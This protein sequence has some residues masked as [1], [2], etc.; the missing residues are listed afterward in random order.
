[1]KDAGMDPLDMD[2]SQEPQYQ[3]G[4]HQVTDT[5]V[6]FRQVLEDVKSSPEGQET[7]VHI[8]RDWDQT[9]KEL[10]VQNP[11]VLQTIQ[12]Q[13]VNGIYGRIDAE[14]QRQRLLGNIPA[15]TPYLAAY[16]Q[17]GDYLVQNGG[18]VDLVQPVQQAANPAPI[19]TTV[20]KVEPT[21]QHNA[22]VAAAAVS[23]TT[24]VAAKTAPNF[25]AM[26]DEDFLKQHANFQGRL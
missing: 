16:K 14:V 22:E 11:D 9:S 1:M 6:A 15:T 2:L 23:R 17:V 3:A 4:N 7:L 19:A 8:D 18:F 20:K 24:P 12:E 13:R 10:L 5:E 26:S 21:V 25:L